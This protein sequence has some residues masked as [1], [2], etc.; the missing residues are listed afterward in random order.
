MVP[1]DHSSVEQAS[2]NVC[3]D[4]RQP[5]DHTLN[6]A[7]Q[8]SQCL[9]SHP[10]TTVPTNDNASNSFFGGRELSNT[11]RPVDGVSYRN[12][13][14]P[15]RSTP[16]SI[17]YYN[18]RSILPKFDCLCAEVRVR[19]PIVV[20]IVE[21]WLSH[22]ISDDEICI[23]NYQICRLDRN[24]HGGGVLM[25]VHDSLSWKQLPTSNLEMIAISVSPICGSSKHCVSVLYRP[26]S[27]PTSF[28]DY[29][30]TALHS[31]SPHC[32]SSFVLVGDFNINF[33]KRDHPYF[34][35]LDSILQ[36][37]SLSQVVQ[38]PTHVNPDGSTSLIDLA[39]VSK[40]DA[41][42]QCPTTPQL[43]D[44]DKCSYHYGIQLTV[45]WKDNGQQVQQ[46]PR[47]IWRYGSADFKKA[48]Q[49]IQETDWDALLPEDDVDLAAANWNNKFM[50]IMSTCI[51]QQSLSRKRNVPWLTKNIVRHIRK[52]NATFQASKRTNKPEVH[53][54]YTHLWNLVVKLMRSSKKFYMRR[55]NV[56]NKKQFWKTVKYMNKKQTSIPE[57]H[58]QDKIAKSELEKAEMLNDFFGT[59]FNTTVDPLSPDA[60]SDEAHCASCPDDLLCTPSEILAFIQALNVDK[61]SGPDGISA[62][63]LK[64]TAASITPSVTKLFNISI[65]LGRFPQVWKSS[66]V[67]PVPKSNNHREASN[68]RPISLL[69]IISK[70][71][72]R[73]YHHLITDHLKEHRPL[74]NKQWGF[75]PGKSTVTSLLS[76]TNEWFQALE[77]G[78]E[79]GAV[80]F[81]LRKAFDTVPHQLLLEKLVNYG[82]DQNII[83]W[84]RSYL[85]GRK[86]HVV[87]GGESSSDAPVLSGVPQGSVLGPLLFLLYID[88]IALTQLR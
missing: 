10:V 87:C 25:H 66:S 28:F 12:E 57:L 56:A 7:L 81:D 88:D 71:L 44:H 19:R 39:L 75:Q 61:A 42:L 22:D 36:M 83:T 63:M 43:A 76:V 69:P 68:Y 16:L 59:C 5:L 30:S 67:V 54:K 38:S 53:S 80:F 64:A 9:G 74:S 27:S 14:I 73:H 20:C 13:P 60:L 11:A 48:N 52:R 51:P 18:A 72:E 41:V 37:F 4:N 40:A 8:A 45:K 26:P 65:R 85:T 46:R 31:L 86:Q 29:F 62:R 17:M 35:K 70:L 21:S 79:V 58:H 6:N 82:F 50:D 78:L 34:C 3:M 84:V 77:K 23:D 1:S 32:F 2:D 33:C 15:R 55:V 24:R 47:K 49:L